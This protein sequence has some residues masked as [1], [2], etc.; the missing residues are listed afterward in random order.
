[1]HVNC[2]RRDQEKDKSCGVVAF[3][4]NP[5]FFARI[6]NLDL[7]IAPWLDEE[8]NTSATNWQRI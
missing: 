8:D 7:L 6:E 2:F 5:I 1:M 3:E 4:G